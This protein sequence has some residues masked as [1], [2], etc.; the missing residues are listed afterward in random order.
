MK[1]TMVKNAEKVSGNNVEFWQ[2]PEGQVPDVQSMADVLMLPVKKGNASTS[3]PS[4]L[5][6]YMFSAK[7]VLASVDEDS[8]T[9]LA[10]INADCGF[11]VEP[12]NAES[13]ALIMKHIYNMD[14]TE[15]EKLGR[16]GRNYALLNFSKKANLQKVVSVVENFVYNGNK[17]N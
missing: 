3:I 13:L 5:P 6:A 11:V 14:K 4:K 7:P 10:I 8:D 12:E 15:L 9:A 17:K 16:K 1:E 2:V